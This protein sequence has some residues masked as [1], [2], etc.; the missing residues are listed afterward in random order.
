MS[1]RSLAFFAA[2]KAGKYG[3]GVAIK[4]EGCGINYES[5]RA[6]TSF[7]QARRDIIAI[8]VD[9]RTGKKKYGRRNGVLGFMRELKQLAWKA[10]IEGCRGATEETA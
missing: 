2:R 3:R 8:D 7:F 1:A 5:F 4:C 6:G 10:H 9:R